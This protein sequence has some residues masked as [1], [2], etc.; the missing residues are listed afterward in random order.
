MLVRFHFLTFLALVLKMAICSAQP[1][2]P[3]PMDNQL[4]DRFWK[5]VPVTFGARYLVALPEGY[6]FDAK[7]KWPL[8]VYL[9]GASSRGREVMKLKE[10]GLTYLVE[11]GKKLPFIV[12]S[13]QCPDDDWW[14]SRW[15]TETV[16]ALVDE[17]L[18][19]Y[20][21]DPQRIYLTGWSMGANGVYSLAIAHPERFAA[22]APLAGKGDS[23][24]GTRLAGLPAW[25]FHGA[26]DKTVAP[27]ESQ[28]MADAIDNVAGDVTLTLIPNADH[29]IWPGVYN[30]P[31][32]YEWFLQHKRIAPAPPETKPAPP[33][34]TPPIVVPPVVAP[35]PTPR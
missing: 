22:I 26:A 3:A 35:V 13:P 14:D 33:T 2:I 32:L 30:N 28:K 8:I 11:K 34:V 16:N 20:A 17:L 25:I 23:Q 27:E 29:E 19:K 21:V 31:K 5:Q 10:Q 18:T 15:M 12:V 24:R 7:K 6:V 9:H 4:A 1:P